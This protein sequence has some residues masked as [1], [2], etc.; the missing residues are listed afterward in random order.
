MQ[1]AYIFKNLHFIFT[2]D[3]KKIL[4]AY[5]NNGNSKKYNL[6]KLDRKFLNDSMKEPMLSRDEEKNLQKLGFLKMIKKLC[7]K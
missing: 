5:N 3:L 7:I 2:Y 1:H 4:L 6:N